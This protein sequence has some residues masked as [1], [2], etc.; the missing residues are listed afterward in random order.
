MKARPAA[1]VVLRIGFP[2]TTRFS[3]VTSRR[4]LRA[5]SPPPE[6]ASQADGREGQSTLLQQAYGFGSMR[7]GGELAAIDAR[8]LRGRKSRARSAVRHGHPSGQV[9]ERFVRA[10][11]TLLRLV[12][13][14]AVE[15]EARGSEL[16]VR[17]RMAARVACRVGQR[18]RR[19][20]RV[21]E[22]L[23]V[24]DSNRTGRRNLYVKSTS[25][26]GREELH[27]VSPEGKIATDWSADGRFLLY[28][29]LDP[30]TAWNL[31]VLPLDGDRKP[32]VFVKTPFQARYARQTV[33]P[34]WEWPLLINVEPE[35]IEL[36]V[37]GPLG[38]AVGPLACGDVAT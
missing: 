21:V 4:P 26:A 7:V 8:L 16:H 25:G 34:E 35:P 17:D 24:F 31:W 15:T 14:V 12:N 27:L 2:N 22:W 10:R 19:V 3:Y 38:G 32:W 36:R 23:I 30:Q 33:A 37:R 6:P 5:A 13:L 1:I 18:A 28:G 29:S 20:P 11:R 9:R